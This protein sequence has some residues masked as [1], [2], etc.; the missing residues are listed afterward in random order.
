[1]KTQ[2]IRTEMNLSFWIWNATK[3]I[4]QFE[5]KWGKYVKRI[6]TKWSMWNPFKVKVKVVVVYESESEPIH[7]DARNYRVNRG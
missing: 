5:T 7:D 2:K 1:M 3:G 4:K 6:D